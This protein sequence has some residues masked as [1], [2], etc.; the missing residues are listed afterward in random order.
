[1][2]LPG[3]LH[4]HRPILLASLIILTAC[5]GGG[6]GISTGSGSSTADTPNQAAVASASIL[7]APTRQINNNIGIG[8][9]FAGSGE[10]P[11]AVALSSRVNYDDLVVSYGHWRDTGGRDG[12]A[13]GADIIRYLQA[14]QSQEDSDAI[15]QGNPSVEI[16]TIPSGLTT[17]TLRMSSSASPEERQ[18][19]ERIMRDINA[20]LPWAN[21]L[22][23]G[24]DFAG[25]I[26]R[27]TIPRGEIHIRFTSGKDTWP[28]DE[29]NGD[30]DEAV[31]GIGGIN[32]VFGGYTLIDARAVRDGAGASYQG[33]LQHVALHELLHAMGTLVHVDP[34]IFPYSVLTPTTRNWQQVPPLYVAIDGEILLAD[35]PA[36][37][38][39]RVRASDLGAWDEQ[40]FHVLGTLPLNASQTM[41]FGAGFRNGLAKPW[42]LGPVPATSVSTNPA[43]AREAMWE[44][45]LLGFANGGNTVAGDTTITID[46]GTH[47]GDVLFDQLEYWGIKAPPGTRGT[48]TVWQD[49]DLNYAIRVVRE[50][51]IE[52]FTSTS[53]T[54]SDPGVVAGAFVGTEHEGATGTLRHPDLSA[55]FGATRQ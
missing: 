28:Q 43:L 20:A 55:G 27:D 54:G 7:P 1:M 26:D 30:Y 4:L 41:E 37:D 13:S 6:S 18:I 22:E 45:Y 23:L 33:L 36:G 32:T 21:R 53:G 44:G 39:A 49:G 3:H 11:E 12:S 15:N 2:K 48:G 51:T 16:V 5:G 35:I 24:R 50:G 17:R 10:R 31:L 38:I 46:F 14:I 9:A 34:A 8:P 29:G 47:R 25:D 40:A 19:I 52:G 42:A